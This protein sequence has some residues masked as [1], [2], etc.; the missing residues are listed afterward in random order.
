MSGFSHQPVSH[1]LF[2]TRMP[3]V[4][5]IQ[6]PHHFFTSST[7]FCL[8]WLL[9]PHI[10]PICSWR[11]SQGSRCFGPHFS[12]YL[13]NLNSLFSPVLWN[14]GLKHSSDTRVDPPV[15]RI[16]N[17]GASLDSAA[18]RYPQFAPAILSSRKASSYDFP[19]HPARPLW[20][21]LAQYTWTTELDRPRIS[22]SKF[23]WCDT[24]LK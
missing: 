3:K 11:T 6:E 10:L 7:M 14:G 1:I 23:T 4:K 18:V 20:R 19:S 16:Y 9:I 21:H 2:W 24:N 12:S 13:W 5:G 15:P 17:S 22:F 8:K